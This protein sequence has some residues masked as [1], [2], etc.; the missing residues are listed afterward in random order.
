MKNFKIIVIS[1]KIVSRL[2]IMVEAL[3][4]IK[5]PEVSILLYHS[6]SNDGTTV[7]I[8]PEDFKFQ[9]EYLKKSFDFISLDQ[10]MDYMSGRINFK[11]PVVA[12]TFDDGYK[13]LIDNV[14][15]ILKKENIPIAVFVLAK[16]D[17]ANREEIANN[18]RLLSFSDI[19]LLQKN[20]W[21]I[22]CHTATHANLALLNK[23]Q[24]S[25]EIIMAKQVLESNLKTIIKFI[26]YPKGIYNSKITSL[27]EKAGYKMGLSTDAGI[28]TNRT[29]RYAV[30]R[31]GIDRTVTESQFP[32][33]L[34]RSGVFYFQVKNTI[35]KMA[36]TKNIFKKL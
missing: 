16:N 36:L 31:V 6:V 11:R 26:S 27:V 20:G 13:D 14:F 12:L 9:I 3:L 17:K 15:P 5:R 23:S 7:D 4:K 10:V 28:L 8:T 33:L 2:I 32:V 1:K 19:K 34:S 25:E 35:G 22:G 21:T 30:P 18:K 24:L 29:S